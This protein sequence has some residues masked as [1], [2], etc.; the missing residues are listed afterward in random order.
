MLEGA[1]DDVQQHQQDDDDN[2]NAEKPEDDGHFFLL[3]RFRCLQGYVQALAPP[4][5]HRPLRR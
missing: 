3:L 2:G 4:E 1:S 5:R